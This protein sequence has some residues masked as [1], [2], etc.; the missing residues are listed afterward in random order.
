[1]GSMYKELSPEERA[2]MQGMV[3]EYYSRFVAVV[4]KHR[5]ISDPETLKLTT[6]GRVF[7]GTR[8][9]ELGLVD[10]LG[11]LEDAI[12]IA[13]KAGN[14]PGAK[15]V[16]YKR[17]YGYKGSIYA[18]NSV[19]QPQAGV[20]KIELPGGPILPGGFYYLWNP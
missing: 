15:V 11:L 19:P 16:M 7:S 13:R 9:K 10:D 17:P 6:D 4:K 12:K 2:V 5:Q 1:M 14:A 18:D 20:H 8:G 3:D